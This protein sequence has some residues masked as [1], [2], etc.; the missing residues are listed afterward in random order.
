M[1]SDRLI[2]LLIFLC[3]CLCL[4]CS[5]DRIAGSTDETEI[6]VISGILIDGVNG[7]PANGAEVFLYRAN[8]TVS[9]QPIDSTFTNSSGK[10]KFDSIPKGLYT[11]TAEYTISSDTLYYAIQNLTLDSIIDIGTDTLK[12]P[13]RISGTVSVEGQASKSGIFCYI[14]GTSYL[15]ITDTGGNYTIFSVPPGVYSFGYMHYK[16]KD[17]TISGVPVYSDVVTNL[18]HM[19]MKIEADSLNK[20]IYGVFEEDYEGIRE[21]E[22]LVRGDGIPVN[23]PLIFPLDW[24]PLSHGFSGYVTVPDNGNNW[25]ATVI[26]YDTNGRKTGF[27]LVDF[28]K[29]AS[30]I[31]VP[32]FNPRNAVPQLDAGQDR[33]VSKNETV[34]FS[35]MATDSF[36]GSIIL[37]R[38]DLDGDGSYDNSSSTNDTVKWVY[39]DTGVYNIL[40]YAL[41]NDSNSAVDTFLVTIPNFKPIITFVTPSKDTVIWDTIVSVLLYATARDSFGGEIVRYQWDFNGDNTWDTVFTENK[42]FTYPYTSGI[43]LAVFGAVDCD[44]NLSVDT[45][46]VTIGYSLQVSAGQDFSLMTKVDGS[47]WGCG[48]CYH[49]TL[50]N[51]INHPP[52]LSPERIIDD[53]SFVSAGPRH[54]AFLQLDGTLLMSGDNGEGQIGNGISGYNEYELL[55]VYVTTL[56][57]QVSLGHDHSLVLKTDGSLWACGR[58]DIS[59]QLGIDSI[60]G[61]DTLMFVMSDVAQ[62][63]AGK[64]HSLARKNDGTLWA[65]GDNRDGQL[66]NGNSGYYEEERTPFQMTSNV[67]FVDAGWHYTMFITNNN[68]LWACGSN[69]FGQLGNGLSGNNALETNPV[70]I[71]DSVAFVSAG[72]EHTMIIKT[73]G[74]LYA[75]GNNEHGQFG[76]GT[77]TN[78]TL[79]RKIMDGVS[80]V[81]AGADHTLIIKNN[82]SV[83]SC[84]NNEY[85]ELGDGTTSNRLFPVQ[86][87]QMK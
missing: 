30:N 87:F 61:S 70:K 7:G 59:G 75:C 33:M 40:F 39:T 6:E 54:S 11:I 66:G 52:V 26:V 74:A 27:G 2:F 42:S 51:G 14:P 50:G 64:Y 63:S 17:T 12:A 77:T 28:T 34:S 45:L 35:G 44:S 73:N 24:N 41:D 43:N 82:G 25:T 15:A 72:R 21:L 71:T 47:V 60:G 80:S 81:S 16:Y 83:W 49:G 86:M 69:T 67:K 36:G 4:H 56:V 9:N 76:N 1:K 22:V 53:I 29:V 57:K 78:S 46:F 23:N 65:W 3:I 13:G 38:W 68:E 31:L 37:Y 84:G 18:P 62:L 58:N 32:A 20:S 19:Q 5:T 10:F 55:P 48:Y 85:G 79:P 8:N